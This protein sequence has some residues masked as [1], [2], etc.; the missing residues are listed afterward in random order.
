VLSQIQSTHQHK[1]IIQLLHSQCTFS[2]LYFCTHSTLLLYY[3][4]IMKLPP[5]HQPAVTASHGPGPLSTHE[6]PQKH[7]HRPS[8]LSHAM[9]CPPASPSQDSSHPM[10][11]AP[12]PSVT[13]QMLQVANPL[14]KML[15]SQVG[16]GLTQ[17]N[18]C[19]R[20]KQNPW[21]KGK[22]NLTWDS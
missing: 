8:H 15:V 6:P 2:D 17:K 5:S 18:A 9:P 14:S 4:H 22:V 10:P 19:S 11:T 7:R 12:M 13:S 20:L 3:I 21:G 1:C 16:V